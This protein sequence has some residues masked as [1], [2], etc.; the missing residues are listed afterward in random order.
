MVLQ[1]LTVF[2]IFL[3]S[4]IANQIKIWLDKDSKFCNRPIK[5]WLQD[6]YIKMNLAHN[7][8]KFIAID[9]LS[10]IAERFIRILKKKNYKYMTS[11]SKK[12][13]LKLDDAYYSTI[14]MKLF[15]VK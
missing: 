5:P 7:E 15:N 6:N 10:V 13:F 4:L 3:M 1:K 8:G 12:C 2:K 9:L 14:K 11:I